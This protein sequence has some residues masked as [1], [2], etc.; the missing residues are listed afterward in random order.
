VKVEGFKKREFIN[1]MNAPDEIMKPET[2][3]T[4]FLKKKI[5]FYAR[6]IFLCVYVYL[7]EE[8]YRCRL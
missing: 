2:D 3:K 5:V 6:Q 1:L 8:V 4:G 7:I